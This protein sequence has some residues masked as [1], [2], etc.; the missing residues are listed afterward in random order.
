MMKI[1]E[2]QAA[3]LEFH[4]R[5]QIA[6][7]VPFKITSPGTAELMSDLAEDVADIAQQ[8]ED[9]VDDP[10]LL[11]MHLVLEEVAEMF[12]AISKGDEV[13]AFDG[14]IDAMY[15][16][17]G[18]ACVFDWPV[19][20]GFVEVHNSNMTKEKQVDDA[21]AARVRKKGPNYRAPDVAKILKQH[22]KQ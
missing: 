2:A 12:L 3:V 16:L 4:R 22:R 13:T 20:E 15:V 9:H 8:L 11:R 21:S 6:P 7:P 10:H 17:F 5:L 14:L 19:Q 1:S 18:V